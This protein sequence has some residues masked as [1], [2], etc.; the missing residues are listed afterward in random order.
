MASLDVLDYV[1]RLDE[2]LSTH[3]RSAGL[4]RAGVREARD[5]I[6]AM[7]FRFALLDERPLPEDFDYLRAIEAMR[8]PTQAAGV[9]AR[10][11]PHYARQRRRRLTTTWGVLAVIAILLGATAYYAT[12]E[13]AQ[14]LAA[15]SEHSAVDVQYSVNQTFLVTADMTRLHMDGSAVVSKLSNGTI[16]VRLLDPNGSPQVTQVFQA[17]GN[18][19]L[20]ANVESPAVGRWTLL[21]DFNEAG[22]AVDVS[23]DGITPTR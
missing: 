4:R 14:T 18:N 11:L 3:E 2:A 9:L 20:R 17:R 21:V 22:G 1:T 7:A 10:R 6:D 15:I 13:R 12:S 23:V 19:F 16:E 8:T 5:L